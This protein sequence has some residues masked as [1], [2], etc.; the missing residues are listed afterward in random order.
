MIYFQELSRLW[1]LLSELLRGSGTTVQI[2]FG[3]VLF[4]LPLGL[5]VCL[6]R[7]SALR[8]LNRLAGVYI[9]ILRGTPLLLQLIFWYFG[10]TMIGINISRFSAVII[11]F[12]FNYAAYFA[13]IY[14]GGL[15]SI[16]KGQYEAGAVLGFSKIKTFQKIIFPQVIKRIIP[17][18]GNELITLV[19]DTSLA[20]AIALSELL[21][22]A[23]SAM[24]RDVNFFPLIVASVFYLIMTGF[25]TKGLSAMEK[26][27]SYYR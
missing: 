15:L 16:S 4:A 24:V 13:E 5:V 3:T 21:K 23:K 1:S 10:L 27:Y 12:V 11:G 19:K 7:M 17:P 6:A 20:Y 25:L 8:L 22:E 14:R 9:F 2:W 26:K 18:M